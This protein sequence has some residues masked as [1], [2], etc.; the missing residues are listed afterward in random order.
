MLRELREIRVYI[1]FTAAV[2]LWL[3]FGMGLYQHW[4]CACRNVAYLLLEWRQE[5]TQSARVITPPRKA[6]HFTPLPPHP[7]SY[8]A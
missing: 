2:A 1:V 3:Q 5:E 7:R 4:D 8:S 6:W